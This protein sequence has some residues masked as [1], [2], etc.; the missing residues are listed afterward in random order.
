MVCG[1]TYLCGACVCTVSLCTVY[2]CMSVYTESNVFTC[3]CM[4][5]FV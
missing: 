3:M 4:H 5:A 1:Y 2:M